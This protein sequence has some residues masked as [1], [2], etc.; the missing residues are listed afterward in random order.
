MWQ[1]EDGA[2]LYGPGHMWQWRQDGGQPS[3]PGY[4][5][6]GGWMMAG[7]TLPEVAAEVL[8]LTVEEVWAEL[9]TGI[10]LAE[11]AANHGTDA[12]AI[13]DAFAEAHAASLQE[14]VEAGWLTQEQADWMQE[15]MLATI[16]ARVNQPWG[17]GFGPGNG[18]GYG[19]GGCHRFGGAGADGS[20]FAPRGRGMGGHGWGSGWQQPA[21]P[22]GPNA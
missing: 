8:G 20:G 9:A 16:E 15:S 11:L 1:Q 18:W 4:G 14:A 7:N 22:Q 3:G 19:L 5:R 21:A 13:I 17:S 12:Q 6:M 10:S 2:Q